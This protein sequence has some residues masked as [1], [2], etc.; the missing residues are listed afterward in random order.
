MTSERLLKTEKETIV[1]TN[2]VSKVA[3]REKIGSNE[4][5]D[6]DDHFKAASLNDHPDE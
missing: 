1:E 5:D 6:R 2:Q 3:F 4:G